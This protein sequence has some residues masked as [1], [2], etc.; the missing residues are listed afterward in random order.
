MSTDFQPEPQPQFQHLA[1]RTVTR[2]RRVLLACLGVLCVGLAAVGVVVPGMPTTVFLIVA[3]ACFMRSCPWLQRVL[4]QN[5]FFGPFL[6]YLEP[7]TVMPVRA[8]VIS[9]AVMWVAISISVALLSTRHLPILWVGGTIVLAGLIGTV[10]IIR[11]GGSPER[12][13]TA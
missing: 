4:V 6:K 10:S 12:P 2:M 11:M 9:I 7:G 3:T 1:A 5:R 13:V 8:K